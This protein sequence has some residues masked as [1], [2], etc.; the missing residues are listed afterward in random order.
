M[1]NI[2]GRL[3]QPLITHY[4]FSFLSRA[5]VKIMANSK[6]QIFQEASTAALIELVFHKIYLLKTW[7]PQYF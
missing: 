4:A 7:R 3:S 1:S 5:Y 6:F 2:T